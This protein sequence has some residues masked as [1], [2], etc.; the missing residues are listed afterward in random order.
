MTPDPYD[1]RPLLIAM[2]G[3]PA[4]GKSTLA[5]GL[6]R[7]FGWPL[8][9][10]DDIKDHTL[11]TPGGNELAYAILWQMV[12]TQLALGLSVIADSPLSYPIGYDMVKKLVRRYDTR[13]LVVETSLAIDEWRR[14][15]ETR[16]P[17]ESAHKVRGWEAMQVLL[18]TY[19]GCWQYP[20]APEHH[21]VVD[22]GRPAADLVAQV[23]RHT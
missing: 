19:D 2:K 21:L 9:D 22:T 12:A 18:R 17:G 20:V 11:A 15:L 4:T 8:L 6:A 10:K 7:A 23:Q 13:L 1:R 14:R 3:H 5:R 16:S